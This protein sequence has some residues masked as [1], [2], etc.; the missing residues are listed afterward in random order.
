VW[1]VRADATVTASA[2][3][4]LA[5]GGA[6]TR[7]FAGANMSFDDAAATIVVADDDGAGA[8]VHV[9]ADGRLR[10]W[11]EHAVRRAG[12]TPTDDTTGHVLRVEPGTPCRWR[13]DGTDVAGIGFDALVGHLRGRATSLPEYAPI[14]D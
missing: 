11:T 12:W 13:L 7:T 9:A 6:I 5:Y 2:P 3:E 8:T 4:D 1:L 14:P 10:Q